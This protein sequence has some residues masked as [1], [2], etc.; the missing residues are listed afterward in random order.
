VCRLRCWECGLHYSGNTRWP[1]EVF[2]K[3][4]FEHVDNV[5]SSLML[6]LSS[7][8]LVERLVIFNVPSLRLG[9]RIS[10]WLLDKN[11]WRWVASES[12]IW[13]TI[14]DYSGSRGKRY[15]KTDL[16]VRHSP[17]YTAHEDLHKQKQQRRKFH[18]F[19][20]RDE[21]ARWLP[22]VSHKLSSR[23]REFTIVRQTGWR[24]FSLNLSAPRARSEDRAA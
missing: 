7:L 11:F 8:S 2:V 17:T 9:N 20:L 1:W 22:L 4:F 24:W 19:I 21:Q 18:F 13:Y 12:V 3:L 6:E 16:G 23:Q 14:S 15:L 10:R 5:P